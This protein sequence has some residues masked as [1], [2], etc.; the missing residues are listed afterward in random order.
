M[1]SGR[2]IALF[3]NKSRYSIINRSQEYLIWQPPILQHEASIL[4]E[5][6]FLN[7]YRFDL[8]KKIKGNFFF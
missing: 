6:I 2:N 1:M 4:T 7:L 5:A 8:I 3:E